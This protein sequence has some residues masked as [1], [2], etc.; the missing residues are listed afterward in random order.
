[1]LVDSHCHLDQIDLSN[2]EVGL[3]SVLADANSRAVQRIL[4][5][6]VDLH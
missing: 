2:K 5:V 4:G 1:M 3:A 6:A